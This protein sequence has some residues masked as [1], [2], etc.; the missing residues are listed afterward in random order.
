MGVIIIIIY[1]YQKNLQMIGVL[2]N[3]LKQVVNKSI[4]PKKKYF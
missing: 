2:V 4:Q 3:Y 1:S